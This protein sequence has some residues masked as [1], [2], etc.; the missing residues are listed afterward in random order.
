MLFYIEQW[1]KNMT[2]RSLINS[3]KKTVMFQVGMWLNSPGSVVGN[4]ISI[5]S[6]DYLQYTQVG[7]Q[8]YPT[9]TR[10]RHAI[11]LIMWR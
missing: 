5:T 10:Q 3:P 9:T 6:Q 2:D 7:V 4:A 11:V 8:L 1:T